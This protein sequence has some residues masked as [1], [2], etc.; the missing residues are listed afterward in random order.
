MPRSDPRGASEQV[1]TMVNSMSPFSLPRRSGP[2][3][4]TA[5]GLRWD[6]F[7][8]PWAPLWE[9]KGPPSDTQVA[10]GISQGGCIEYA[11]ASDNQIVP[12]GGLQKV[13]GEPGRAKRASN[14]ALGSPSR[15]SGSV[16]KTGASLAG[17]QPPPWGCQPPFVA[18]RGC[19]LRLWG[20]WR[21]LRVK[22]GILTTSDSLLDRFH[23]QIRPAMCAGAGKYHGQLDV[24]SLP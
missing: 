24:F 2:P 15:P 21:A 18:L 6:F 9:V 16:W 19:I 5:S 1:N 17:T 7:G 14:V 4:G 11:R 10:A 8:E 23:A 12:L 13:L 3:L 22:A 20:A